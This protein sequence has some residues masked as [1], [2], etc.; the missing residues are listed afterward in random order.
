MRDRLT[1]V[2]AYGGGTRTAIRG[3]S[4]GRRCRRWYPVSSSRQPM[5]RRLCNCVLVKLLGSVRAATAA[6]WRQCSMSSS[7]PASCP[8]PCC[9]EDRRLPRSLQ[10]S[11]YALSCEGPMTGHCFVCE[12]QDGRNHHVLSHQHSCDSRVSP[13]KHHDWEVFRMRNTPLCNKAP[14]NLVFRRVHTCIQPGS[15]AKHLAT[16]HACETVRF[17][18]RVGHR[19]DTVRKAGRGGFVVS[20]PWLAVL[21][22]TSAIK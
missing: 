15:L 6:R 9:C 20:G 4:R 14:A 3:P 18:R 8:S 17:F 11:F 7:A 2:S 10:C 16:V 19:G 12:T 13:A 22:H 1:T 21:L 5:C